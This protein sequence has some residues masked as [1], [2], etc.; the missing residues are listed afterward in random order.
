MIYDSIMNHLQR[1]N[2]QNMLVWFT[3]RR[4][5]AVRLAPIPA[6]P[7]GFATSYCD[8]SSYKPLPTDNV[9]I[10]FDQ[11]I[12][13]VE[14]TQWLVGT[15][16]EPQAGLLS[17]LSG[18]PAYHRTPSQMAPDR[19]LANADWAVDQVTGFNYQRCRLIKLHSQTMHHGFQSWINICCEHRQLDLAHDWFVQ[20][21]QKTIVKTK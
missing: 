9:S 17:W 6:I 13:N 20:R 15:S 21:F 2:Y 11:Q 19:P 1:S 8:V 14:T 10:W 5:Q 18:P 4:T 16:Q 7:E 3:P 12:P